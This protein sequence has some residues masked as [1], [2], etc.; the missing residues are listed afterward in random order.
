MKRRPPANA[1]E[2]TQIMR[3]GPRV[4]RAD[5]K[6][7]SVLRSPA[8][9]LGLAL[10]A[11]AAGG[12]AAWVWHGMPTPS[13][14]PVVAD[15]PPAPQQAATPEPA[16]PEQAAASQ[17]A[18]ATQP[19]AATQSTAAPQP[20]VASQPTAA[21]Q[22]QAALPKDALPQ[23]PATPRITNARLAE[24]DG[25]RHS[26]TAV[27][28]LIENPRI[29]LIDFPT[30]AEQGRAMNRLAALIEKSGMPHD[31][32]LSEAEI[33]L[34]IPNPDT[35]YYAHDYAATSLA[36]FF[37]LAEAETQ[38]LNPQERDLLALLVG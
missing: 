35:Y 4:D 27:Y 9:W 26:G 17:S 7:R 10:L 23:Q 5:G 36:R 13:A 37:S 2:D 3:R 20:T 1:D 38:P 6:R 11:I 16:A 28:R 21:P 32:V 8:I 31:R 19:T 30:L 24:I 22:Q 34:A 33:A 14:A 25:L 29:L 12:A 18:A 15:A